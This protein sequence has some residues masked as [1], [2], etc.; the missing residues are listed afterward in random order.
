MKVYSDSL[1]SKRTR[2]ISRRAF[3][4][5]SATQAGVLLRAGGLITPFVYSIVRAKERVSLVLQ[6]DW[7]TNVQFAGILLADYRGW[8][9]KAGIELVIHPW[10]HGIDVIERVTTRDK[11]T[12]GDMDAPAIIRS[13]AQGVPIKA[14]GTMFQVF[15]WGIMSLKDSGIT[16][17]QQL[18]GK[19]IGLHSPYDVK[20]LQVVLAYVGLTLAD[21]SVVQAG[22]DTSVL[23]NG[24]IDAMQCYIMDEPAALKAKGIEVNIIR[25]ADY[26]YTM[27]AQVFF[28]TEHL[29]RSQP[30][31]IKTFLSVSF[32]GWREALKAPEETAR[33][34]VEHYYPAGDLDYQTESMKLLPYIVTKGVGAPLIGM[35]NR[36]I[37]NNSIE[38]LVQFGILQKKID[39]DEVFTLQFLK[40]I[41]QL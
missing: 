26:G 13:R 39:P 11:A 22:F 25:A 7:I 10:E 31:L 38:L 18:K 5:Q 3:L 12:I 14:V 29:M 17:P 41:Y 33:L 6:L 28:C 36:A 24:E 2:S 4:L 37:W 8:Y 27:Y 1:L 20:T 9:R 15:L 23:L 16:T 32:D 30:D 19:K 40:E 21:V 34:V 35:M